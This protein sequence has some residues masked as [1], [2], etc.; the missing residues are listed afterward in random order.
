MI[1]YKI[2]ACHICGTTIELGFDGTKYRG[3]CYYCG[4]E[5]IAEPNGDEEL[6]QN[7]EI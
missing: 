4:E 1:I 6:I 5:L 7:G 2:V 3:I